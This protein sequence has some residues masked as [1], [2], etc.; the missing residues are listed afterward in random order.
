MDD[1]AGYACIDKKDL[2]FGLGWDDD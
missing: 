1:M 2:S